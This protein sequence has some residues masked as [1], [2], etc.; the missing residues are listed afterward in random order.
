MEKIIKNNFF[1]IV[2]VAI[3][4]VLRLYQLSVIPPHPSLDEATIGYN[5]YSILRTGADEY[6]YKFPVLLRAYDDW[7]PALYTYF[8]I[9]FVK[10]FDLNVLSVRLPSALLSI[11]TIVS[12]FVFSK[13]I[14]RKFEYKLFGL[15]LSP[16]L[17]ITILFAISPWDVYISRLG[18]EAN[19]FFSFLIFAITFFF[20]FLNLKKYKW[21]AASTIFFALSFTAYQNGKIV[22]PIIVITLIFLFAKDLLQKRNY[23]ILNL[24]LGILMVA[25]VLIA[26]LGP[27]ALVRFQA[28]NLF[29]DTA[30]LEAKSAQNSIIDREKHNY[31]GLLFD[32]RRLIYPKLFLTS[33]SSHFSL[34]WL[35]TNGGDE[36]FKIP[37]L[38]LIYLYELPLILLGLVFFL[39]SERIEKKTKIF[40]LI[41]LFS[42]VLPAAITNGYPHAMR[43]FQL[44]PVFV[45]LSGFGLFSFIFLFKGKQT[46]NLLSLVAF[47]ILAASGVMLFRQYF[48][49]F[50]INTAHQF[51]YGIRDALSFVSVNEKNYNKIYV[52]NKKNLFESYMFYLFFTKYDP[53]EYQ[54]EGGT[55]SGGFDREHI[56]GKYRFVALVKHD[57]TDSLVVSNPNDISG[58]T[59]LKT[60]YLP[61]NKDALWITKK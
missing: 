22:V 59:R 34:F 12:V 54:K 17:F 31:I 26:S 61:T 15:N 19:A 47:I 16:S 42:S 5:A 60:I 48:F 57:L 43:A 51:Q 3:G 28:T 33:Y 52:D 10:A 45:L 58:G 36:Q 23:L 37:G 6:G 9:P 11:A 8:V 4:A 1:L 35:A 56:I 40:L 24:V 7:R 50:P 21:L 41:W 29:S 18:H 49:V 14:F 30:A 2:I 13:I 32:N 44:Q 27:N 20:L 53:S 25:P 55:V 46:R 39:R 38:G